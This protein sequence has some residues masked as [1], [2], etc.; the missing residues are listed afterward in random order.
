LPDGYTIKDMSDDYATIIKEEFGGPV[1]R[2]GVSTGGAIAQHFASDHPDL[3]RKLIIH[4]SA[5]TLSNV[6][7]NGELHIKHLAR[8]HHWREAFTIF[9][10]PMFPQ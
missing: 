6:G 4:S 3:L 2:R 8:Q 7:I 1:D 9:V 10:S 5:F